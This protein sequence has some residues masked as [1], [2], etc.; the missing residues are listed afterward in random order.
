MFDQVHIAEP[1]TWFRLSANNLFVHCVFKTQELDANSRRML[2]AKPRN[3]TTRLQGR[4]MPNA[5]G[6]TGSKTHTGYEFV[7]AQVIE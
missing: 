7:V 2:V 4:L 3:S 1:V 5:K 6:L